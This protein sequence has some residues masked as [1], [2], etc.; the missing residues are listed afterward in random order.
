MTEKGDERTRRSVLVFSGLDPSG[1]AGMAADVEAIGAAAAH[2]LPIVTALTVQDNDRVYQV[3][4]VDAGIL[5][6]QADV[7]L[8]KIPISAVKVGIVGNRV[9]ADAIG[10]ILLRLRQR[11]P[12]LPVVLDTV[13]G[14]G[15]G[16]SLADGSP[17]EALSPLIPLATLVTPNLPEAAR[18]AP[19]AETVEEQAAH[20]LSL[21]AKE[22]LIK[23]GHSD[24]PDVVVNRWFR[25]GKQR[26]WQWS[27]MNGEFHGTGCTLA[28]G[29]A[30]YLARGFV[31]EEA[32]LKGQQLCRDAIS[33]AFS[34]AK[35]QKI[36]DRHVGRSE[37]ET[38]REKPR[39]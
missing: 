4:P 15:H 3:C 35:G 38:A 18:L 16:F 39:F 25:A 31:M 7:L 28:S 24:D 26:Q 27:R 29:V 1:G 32:L 30:G 6:R 33:N 22:V 5:L 14:S 10:E 20:L 13:L 37:A 2:A 11:H 12:D 36:P 21:G 34:I 9:N 17:E 8:R 23:G 19:H